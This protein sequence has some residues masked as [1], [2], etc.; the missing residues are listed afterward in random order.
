[1]LSQACYDIK[2]FTVYMPIQYNGEQP[3]ALLL[4]MDNNLKSF[5]P[6]LQIAIIPQYRLEVL[7]NHHQQEVDACASAITEYVSNHDNWDKPILPGGGNCLDLKFVPEMF[8]HQ[9]HLWLCNDQMTG[10]LLWFK[11]IY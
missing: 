6:Y 3:P 9:G 10:N 7:L 8:D 2:Q 5:F 1:M 4:L 11:H